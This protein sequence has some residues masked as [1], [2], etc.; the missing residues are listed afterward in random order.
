MAESHTADAP[1][2]DRFVLFWDHVPSPSNPYNL[3]VFSQWFDAPF[4]D[5]RQVNP[6]ADTPD[7]HVV[8]QT[9][10]HWMMYHKALLFDRSACHDILH[11][12]TPA[13]AKRLGRE[14]K[15]FNRDVW[16]RHADDIVERGNRA[17]FHPDSAPR[18]LDG[19]GDEGYEQRRAEAGKRWETLQATRGKRMI[20]A[21]PEDRIWGI[22]CGVED[23]WQR[24]D[25][26]GL[27]R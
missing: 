6:I 7:K 17:K 20:E 15:G 27:N 13:D 5:P 8:Y 4:V 24:R 16:N 10:E 3:A 9:A 14:I 18:K 26:W 21:S 25:N 23:A 1:D 22:G 2:K 19:K 12:K 11:A